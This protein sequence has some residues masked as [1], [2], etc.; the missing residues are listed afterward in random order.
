MN[1]PN[2]ITF[3]RI[4]LIPVFILI[5]YDP[6]P[7][8][9]EWAAVIFLVA[10]LTDWVDGYIARRWGQVTLMGKFLDPIADKLLV[11]SALILLVDFGRVASWVAIVILGRE[12]AVTGLRAIAS[13][14]GVVIQAEE[15][16]KYKTTVQLAAL[17]LLILPDPLLIGGSTLSLH[18]VGTYALW[19]AV[20]LALV[21]GGQYFYRFWK[22][23]KE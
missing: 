21:S 1:L 17:T 16:G 6:T 14:I 22:G 23:T 11:L 20:L 18:R 8:R 15:M 19:A 13:S 9:A 10:S 4:L 12:L 5:F 3:S 7:G 2:L